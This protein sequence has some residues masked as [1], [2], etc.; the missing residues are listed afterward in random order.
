[1]LATLAHSVRKMTVLLHKL[2]RG[3]GPEQR[4]PLA[5]AEVLAQAVRA[6]A[7]TL[8]CPSLDVLDSGLDV[9]AD[10]Q[11]LERVLGHLIQNA[12]EATSAD[13]KVALSLRREG[14]SAVIELS[15]SGHGMSEQFIR[16]RLFKPFDSTKPAGMGIGM[17]E[18]RDYLCGIGG[19]LEVKSAPGQ[20]ST[21]RIILPLHQAAAA[22]A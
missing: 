12:I 8:P 19:R 11:R 3:E 21:F 5:L 20:G 7:V 9:L 1:M 6:R 2:S 10:R 14:R 13:G 18:S 15:D 22:A 17:F 4:A 16:E